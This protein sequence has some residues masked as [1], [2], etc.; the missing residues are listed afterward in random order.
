METP[1]D[2]KEYLSEEFIPKQAKYL[3]K[4]QESLLEYFAEGNGQVA[5]FKSP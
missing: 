1:E 4:K 5:L 2:F 3:S